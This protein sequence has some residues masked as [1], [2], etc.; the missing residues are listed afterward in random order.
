MDQSLTAWM[1]SGGGRRET[2]EDRRQRQH[3]TALHEA[4]AA[5]ATTH[6]PSTLRTVLARWT[7]RQAAPSP[8]LTLDC[9]AA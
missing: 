5:R 9:C 3:R 2:V 8:A 7:G 1:M 4:A 6:G